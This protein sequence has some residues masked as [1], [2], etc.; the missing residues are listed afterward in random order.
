MRLAKRVRTAA[1]ESEV[2]RET[3]AD[4]PSTNQRVEFVYRF[5]N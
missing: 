5:G 1:L 3:G 2:E 4:A